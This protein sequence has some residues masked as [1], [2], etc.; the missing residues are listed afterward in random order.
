L[1]T[2]KNNVV[3]RVVQEKRTLF[4]ECLS[5]QHAKKLLAHRRNKKP[6]LEKLWQV[7]A[8]LS[9]LGQSIKVVLFPALLYQAVWD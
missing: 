1:L 5:L 2:S 8:G 3:P 9:P 6:P 7:L 4:R